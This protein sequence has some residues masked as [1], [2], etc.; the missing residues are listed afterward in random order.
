V[1]PERQFPGL[2]SPDSQPGRIRRREMA[3]RQDSIEKLYT[4]EEL[5]EA[6]EHANA[7]FIRSIVASEP[8]CLIEM[9]ESARKYAKHLNK[10]PAI[11][12]ILRAYELG[13]KKILN[14]K[15]S[16]KR[17]SSV[18]LAAEEVLIQAKNIRG[19]IA[20]NE[21][22]KSAIEMMILVFSVIHSEMFG[23]FIDGIKK[24]LQ[25]RHGG[26]V[27][28]DNRGYR[29]AIKKVL[30]IFGQ[31][32]SAS[33]IWNH[34]KKNHNKKEPMYVE[35]YEIYFE[36]DENPGSEKGERLIQNLEGEIRRITRKT[37]STRLKE[38]RAI[39]KK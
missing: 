7:S 16:Y 26:G 30:E 23:L 9:V 19:S 11:E 5:Y 22:E 36:P 33:F 8:E 34:F 27:G 4:L 28:R 13:A 21:A 10:E 24:R 3:S 39:R 37:L 15:K 12:Y 18:I 32:T 17:T 31:K 35:E 25:P 6:S 38:V 29:L 2:P 14:D 20:A 1:H